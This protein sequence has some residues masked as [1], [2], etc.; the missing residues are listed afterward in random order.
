[1]SETRIE[2]KPDKKGA[3]WSGLFH[4]AAIFMSAILSYDYYQKGHPT[5]LFYLFFF[6]LWLALFS[7]FTSVGSHCLLL[8]PRSL[9]SIKIGHR[10]VILEW[11]N[12][13]ADEIVKKLQFQKGRTILGLW[14]QTTDKRRVQATIR[15]NSISKEEDTYLFD[16]LTRIR[17][18]DKPKS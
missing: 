8:F 11:K 13:D 5:P 4:G 9:K 16:E 15:R 14:G 1:M 6:S 2:L 10:S 12:G 3:L 18:M 7:G 17:D